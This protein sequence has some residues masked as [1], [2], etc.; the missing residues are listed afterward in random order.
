LIA[1]AYDIDS[2]GPFTES[3]DGGHAIALSPTDQVGGPTFAIFKVHTPGALARRAIAGLTSVEY[4][5]YVS[6][7]TQAN[8]VPAYYLPTATPVTNFTSSDLVSRGFA[9]TAAGAWLRITNHAF[10][11]EAEASYLDASI[12]NPS[13]V[14]GVTITEPV[15][16]NQLGVALQSDVDAVFV[17]LGVD[18]GYASGDPSAHGFN[19]FPTATAPAAD[20]PLDNTVN[21][22]RFDPDYHIDQILFREI[23][24][25]VTDAVYVRPHVATTLMTVGTS[26][27]EASTA[28]IASW[29]VEPNQT[30]SGQRPLGVELDPELRYA[31]RDGFAVTIDYGVL[32]PGTAFDNPT[33]HLTAQTAQVLRAR[34]FFVF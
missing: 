13:F 28:L 9:A 31:S 8:D 5:G 24:G 4:A 26:R 2:T 1:V 21:N 12:A 16:A 32:F 20:P 10:R 25:L 23:I 30:P 34:L 11:F 3:K 29:A 7:R 17:R 27:L 33:A 22:F 18:G 19:A 6:Y 14:P 15:T